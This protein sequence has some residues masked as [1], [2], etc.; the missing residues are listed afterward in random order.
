TERGVDAGFTNEVIVEIE[1][2]PGGGGDGVAEDA[3]RRASAGVHA[4]EEASVAALFKELGVARPGVVG[5]PL[6][7]GFEQFGDEGVEVPA[8]ACSV[9]VDD[10]DL[11]GAGRLGAADGGVDFLGVELAAFLVQRRAAVDLFP[12][13]DAAD[14]FHV[15]HD[16]D[17]H[18]WR[19]YGEVGEG[20]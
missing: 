9:A 7:V 19:G 2:A 15:G 1:I 5:D 16:E 14:A 10:N 3:I 4:D 13:D 12:D 11:L 18:G 6:A 20:G 8:A 17:A